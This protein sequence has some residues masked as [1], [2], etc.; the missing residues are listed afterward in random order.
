MRPR[1]LRYRDCPGRGRSASAL[2]A[3]QPAQ[4]LLGLRDLALARRRQ[5]AAGAV[6]VE[7]EH[8]HGR[9]ERRR[10]APA[11]PLRRALQGA[12]HLLGR[13]LEDA[14]LQVERVARLDDP[15]GPVAAGRALRR[16]AALRRALRRHGGT[17][18]SPADGASAGGLRLGESSWNGLGRFAPRLR[19]R[20]GC[21]RTAA[22]R[23]TPEA[24]SN[25]TSFPCSTL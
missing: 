20:T 18:S 8:R 22:R 25:A 21:A 6:L 17:W 14:L 4:F 13:E 15:L 19:S 12:R 11:A 23:A 24:S 3:E 1:R 7:R 16:P 9:A 2:L 5:L 10:L